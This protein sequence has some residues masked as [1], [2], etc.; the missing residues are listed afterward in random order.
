[1]ASR[2]LLSVTVQLQS[3]KRITT[4]KLDLLIS[5][6]CSCSKLK[7]EG[8]KNI[9]QTE[10]VVKEIAVHVISVLVLLLIKIVSYC[11]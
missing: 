10:N 2:E 8:V 1:M 7:R 11:F 3:S 4:L 9:S 5:N 6:F